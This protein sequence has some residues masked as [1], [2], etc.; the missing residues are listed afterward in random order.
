MIRNPMHLVDQLHFSILRD[1]GE[2]SKYF[3]VMN[4]YPVLDALWKADMKEMIGRVRNTKF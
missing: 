4:I 1:V 2:D 3:G